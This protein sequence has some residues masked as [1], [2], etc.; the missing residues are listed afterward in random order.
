VQVAQRR[1]DRV[2]VAG[3][4]GLS[5]RQHARLPGALQ[6]AAVVARTQGDGR[7]AGIHQARPQRRRFRAGGLQREGQRRRRARHRSLGK[8]ANGVA[9]AREEHQ[10]ARLGLIDGS[11]VEP[12][13]PSPQHHAGC[14]THA[15]DDRADRCVPDPAVQRERDRAGI[16]GK[17][18]R[19]G[20]EQALPGRAPQVRDADA[21][22]APTPPRPFPTERE[23]DSPDDGRP[24]CGQRSRG[25]PAR[26]GHPGSGAG[27]E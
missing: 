25:R 5:G 2:R 18:V 19:A 12:W 22:P 15:R 16:V 10:P 17:D 23:V 7:P 8:P 24:G 3:K 21:A 4:Q 14:R 1:H 26:K 20:L 9:L 11:V 6:A 27:D 13:R